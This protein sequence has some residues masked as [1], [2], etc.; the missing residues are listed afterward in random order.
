[1]RNVNPEWYYGWDQEPKD[2]SEEDPMTNTYQR[3]TKTRKIN[4]A[5]LKPGDVLL[6][7]HYGITPDDVVE[8]ARAK[9]GAILRTV[10]EVED[11]EPQPYERQVRRIV[12][13]TDGTRSVRIAPIQTWH[14]LDT[15]W[16]DEDR[17]DL[18]AHFERDL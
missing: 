17:A 3:G 9:T 14:A 11:T 10:E 15:S 5:R 6:T 2:K 1:M 7:A 8:V 4:T 13:F 18:H 12:R 16:S